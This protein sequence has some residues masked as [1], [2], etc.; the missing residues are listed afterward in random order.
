MKEEGKGRRGKGRGEGGR[1]RRGGGRGMNRKGEKV[2]QHRT[3][4]ASREGEKVTEGA[5]N[6]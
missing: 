6:G 1:E 2:T 4:E 3:A 5:G